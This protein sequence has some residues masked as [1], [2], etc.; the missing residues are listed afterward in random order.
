MINS[1]NQMEKVVTPY[2]RK[3][4]ELTRDRIFEVVSQKVSD[5]YNERVFSPPDED[6]PDVYKRG[7]AN[8]NL[9]E[10]LTATHIEQSGNTLSF[11]V[12]FDKEYLEFHYPFSGRGIPATGL[13]VLTWMDNRSHGG[14]VSGEHSY[15]TEAINELGGQD[16]LI[17]LFKDNC[18]RVGLPLI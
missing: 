13:D 17:K 3:A 2:I 5:Y 1:M 8:M 4:M 11:R 15:W 6:V 14:T 7:M 16:G 12:G 18:K 9:M 10:S